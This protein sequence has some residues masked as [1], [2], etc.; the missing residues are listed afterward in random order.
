MS[1]VRIPALA[2]KFPI[3]YELKDRDSNPWF[4]EMHSRKDTRCLAASGRRR[5]WRRTSCWWPGRS[6]TPARPSGTCAG[7]PEQ[8]IFFYYRKKSFWNTVRCKAADHFSNGRNNLRSFREKRIG[9]DWKART[10]GDG[11]SANGPI[12]F[13]G[14]PVDILW[15]N[16]MFSDIYWIKS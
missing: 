5:P 7:S 10:N 9:L 8:G 6:T 4:S 1:S 2:T 16:K 11:P 13:I 12:L 3:K 14:K 15:H